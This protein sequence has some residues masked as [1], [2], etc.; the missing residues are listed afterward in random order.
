MIPTSIILFED[1][2]CDFFG[3]IGM[4]RPIWAIRF[5][6][7]LLREYSLFG[8][9]GELVRWVRP[10]LVQWQK[11]LHPN[12]KVNTSVSSRCLLLNGRMVRAKPVFSIQDDEEWILFQESN[13]RIEIIAAMLTETNQQKLL[14]QVSENGFSNE[15][16]FSLGVKTIQISEHIPLIQHPFDA[17]KK[18]DEHLV[19]SIQETVQQGFELKSSSSFSQSNHFIQSDLIFIH[20]SVQIGEQIVFDASEGPILISKDVVI[21]SQVFLKGPLAIGEGCTLRSGLRLYGPSSIGPIC[22]LGGEIQNSLWMGYS[23][24][25]HDGYIGTAVIGSWV[26]IGAG[27]NNSDLKNTYGP[28]TI[29]IQ[30]HR[31]ETGEIHIGCLLGDHTKTSIGLQLNTGTV[32]GIAVN[33][34]GAGFPPTVV[35]SFSWGGADWLREHQLEKAIETAKIVMSRRK[36]VFVTEIEDMFR[37]WFEKTKAERANF[38]SQPK[39]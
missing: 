31:I 4:L 32:T 34:F 25:Q 13:H 26:N 15:S 30:G 23:N 3:G 10:H 11:H 1:E 2:F 28:I 16:F 22:K 7:G 18:L 29:T 8:W 33:L 9:N 24:K 38:R 14:R 39:T 12:T 17:L 20:P 35:P 21:E 27:T 36:Q 37:Y 19:T 5:G 6:N